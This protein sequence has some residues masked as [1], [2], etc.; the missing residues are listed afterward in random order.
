MDNRVRVA[1]LVERL[2]Q[3]EEEATRTAGVELEAVLASMDA[4][5][6]QAEA[7]TTYTAVLDQT[8]AGLEASTAAIEKCEARGEKT[9]QRLD[10][11]EEL[12]D[13]PAVTGQ[14]PDPNDD[15]IAVGLGPFVLRIKP[16]HLGVGFLLMVLLFGFEKSTDLAASVLRGGL[17]SADAPA[18]V[19]EAP[20]TDAPL[21][22]GDGP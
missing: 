14:N 1:L 19:I 9:D 4:G 21:D 11:I 22:A 10:R 16:A 8:R 20:A 18:D 7:L 3:S 2:K 6:K 12:L 15:R 17:L 5:D 13:P